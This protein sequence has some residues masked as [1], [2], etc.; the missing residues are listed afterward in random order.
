MHH[1]TALRL[2]GVL[3]EHGLVE[4]VGDRGTYR[5]GFALIPLAGRVAERL[6]ITTHAHPIWTVV[7][8]GS[9][10]EYLRSP[11]CDLA[12]TLLDRGVD[13]ARARPLTGRSR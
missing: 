10:P 5:L 3:A 7:V 13:C 2:L 1:S 12:L 9:P 8:I 6:E 11:R 4:Q